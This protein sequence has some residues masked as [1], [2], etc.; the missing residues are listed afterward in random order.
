MAPVLKI[1]GVPRLPRG[2]SLG[3]G[4]RGTVQKIWRAVPILLVRVILKCATEQSKGGLV[5]CSRFMGLCSGMLSLKVVIRP[6]W[7]G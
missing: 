3:T 2:G 7:L 4:K 1:L 5:K 6:T